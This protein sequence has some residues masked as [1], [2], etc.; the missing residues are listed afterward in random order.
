MSEAFNSDIEKL[1]ASTKSGIRASSFEKKLSEASK[2]G[3]LAG[4]HDSAGQI[5][6]VVAKRKGLIIDDR[7]DR[8]AR[9]KDLRTIAGEAKLASKDKKKIGE[10]LE[11]LG[12]R[13]SVLA[14]K[15]TPK[16]KV[17]VKVQAKEKK[18]MPYNFGA[19]SSLNSG[20]NNSL[21]SGGG[22]QPVSRPNVPRLVV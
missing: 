8:S 7:Y 13:K 17:S 19:N 14:K 10:I 5:A 20:V 3:D 16:Q 1:V 4:L 22:I 2:G 15:E 18:R 12:H 6:E 11:G 9:D 21:G